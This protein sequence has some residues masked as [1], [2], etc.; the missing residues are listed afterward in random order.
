MYVPSVDRIDD[1]IGYTI[2]N[3]QLMTWGE[4]DKKAHDDMRDGKLIGGNKN[5]P[6]LQFTKDG[7]F[8]AEYISQNEASRQNE[9]NSG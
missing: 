4:N 1:N 7:K 2:S 9:I 5:K 6:V 3:I 8:I